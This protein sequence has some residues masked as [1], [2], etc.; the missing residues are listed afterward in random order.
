MGR[1]PTFPVPDLPTA[2]A[3]VRKAHP[4]HVARSSRGRCRILQKQCFRPLFPIARPSFRT[5]KIH[6]SRPAGLLSSRWVNLREMELYR[7]GLA[8]SARRQDCYAA[9]GVPNTRTDAQ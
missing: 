7:E 4:L 6:A 8:G 3:E 5:V 1:F 2:K 9:R